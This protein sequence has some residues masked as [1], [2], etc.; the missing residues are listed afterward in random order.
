MHGT[1]C[2]SAGESVPVAKRPGDPVISGA[3]S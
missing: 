1:F 2:H 3:L